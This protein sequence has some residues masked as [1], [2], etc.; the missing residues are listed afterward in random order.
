M[1]AR[2]ALPG[3]AQ[4]VP[5]LGSRPPR[6]ASLLSPVLVPT[7]TVAIR[8]RTCLRG[9][10]SLVE[11]GMWPPS[12]SRGLPHVS[13]KAGCA[14]CTV[15]AWAQFTRRGGFGADGAAKC[16]AHGKPRAPLHVRGRQPG[17]QQDAFEIG[18]L[19]HVA[20]VL[21]GREAEAHRT[22]TRSCFFASGL[23]R[24]GGR[25]PTQLPSGG[26]VSHGRSGQRQGGPLRTRSQ[27]EP[28]KWV[29]TRGAR[30]PVSWKRGGPKKSSRWTGEKNRFH[31]GPP[32]KK[33]ESCVCSYGSYAVAEG[34]NDFNSSLKC[35]GNQ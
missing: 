25:G 12:L 5:S 10:E 30:P 9:Q 17:A 6:T 22:R 7:Q 33:E 34:C 21:P 28:R 35:K 18:V 8:S 19:S 15:W 24:A 20:V 26:A 2:P 29:T 27:P 31:P 3:R 16:E 13:I 23:R 4:P 11:E 1:S 14:L 32:G